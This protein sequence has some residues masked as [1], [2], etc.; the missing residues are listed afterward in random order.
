MAV[1]NLHFNS[2]SLRLTFV[3]WFVC[4]FVCLGFSF[5]PFFSTVSFLFLWALDAIMH[6]QPLPS[7]TATSHGEKSNEMMNLWRNRRVTM[8]NSTVSHRLIALSTGM[9]GNGWAQTGGGDGIC[10][11]M[12]PNISS[13]Y[14]NQVCKCFF[15]LTRKVNPALITH[16][17]NSPTTF[18]SKKKTKKNSLSWAVPLLRRTLLPEARADFYAWPSSSYLTCQY[19]RDLADAHG[20]ECCPAAELS[21]RAAREERATAKASLKL[22]KTA[23]AFAKHFLQ[24]CWRNK[25]QEGILW[26]VRNL[27]QTKAS[28]V[29]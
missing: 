21:T 24:S 2:W 28:G 26:I 4:L 14:L 6:G 13:G 22:A 1:V 25:S 15:L 3:T 10:G 18:T 5:L 11:L 17:V 9:A 27:K 16:A 8:I 7:P 23:G 29:I 19:Q 20:S 12:H